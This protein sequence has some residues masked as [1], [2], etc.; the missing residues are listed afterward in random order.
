MGRKRWVGGVLVFG[1]A[2]AG[3]ATGAPAA[4]TTVTQIADP[5]PASVGVPLTIT[6]T[7]TNLGPSI[8]AT[9]T[10]RNTLPASVQFRSLVATTGA[11]CTIPAV[12]ATG[13]VTCVW[14][15]PA[16][17]AA[18]AM[19]IS[20]VPT[21]LVPLSNAASVVSSIADPVPANNRVTAVINTIPYATGIGGVRCTIIGSPGDDVISATAGDDVIC[22][23]GGND[24]IRSWGGSDFIDGGDGDDL[25]IGGDGNDRIYGRAGNDRVYGGRD[26]DL[27]AG[28]AGDDIVGGGPGADVMWGGAGF[29]IGIVRGSGDRL[30]RIERRVRGR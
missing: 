10:A 13:T 21:K 3:V 15:K 25:L 18:Q 28:G 1:M 19:T 20:A 26:N 4:D 2:A 8:P 27:V 23:L 17:G 24:T 7:A 29:D 11:K 22:G 12:G 16:L 9:M 14:A 6:V 5:N 30:F